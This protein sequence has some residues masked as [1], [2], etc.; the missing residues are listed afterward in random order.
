[1]KTRPCQ[2]Q[3][4]GREWT[5]RGKQEVDA[6]TTLADLGV[7][8]AWLLS[9][10]PTSDGALRS[11]LE[12][13]TSLWAIDAISE[14]EGLLL[15]PESRRTPASGGD[16]GILAVLLRMRP[17]VSALP[18]RPPVDRPHIG[19]LELTIDHSSLP[20]SKGTCLLVA[21]CR[22]LLAARSW[23]CHQDTS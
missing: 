7:A 6:D 15:C 8:V 21:A 16:G 22:R 12:E 23:V 19:P 17:A 3:A 1:M 4:T 18:R 10:S 13:P 11:E 5:G 2:S 9:I 20:I 14:Y